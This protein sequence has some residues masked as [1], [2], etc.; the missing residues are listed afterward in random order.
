MARSEFPINS[1]TEA[2][3][4]FI[5]G[6]HTVRAHYY[7]PPSDISKEHSGLSFDPDVSAVSLGGSASVS[8]PSDLVKEAVF[9]HVLE[10]NVGLCY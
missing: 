4:N 2:V 6:T 5:G 7:Y 9:S 10:R 8:L 3:T 1:S